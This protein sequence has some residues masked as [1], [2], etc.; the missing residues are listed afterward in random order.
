MALVKCVWAPSVQPVVAKTPLL[1]SSYVAHWAAVRM[2][3]RNYRQLLRIGWLSVC[4]CVC[5]CV[6]V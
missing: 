6:C 2:A 1:T 5:V 4:E 3:D